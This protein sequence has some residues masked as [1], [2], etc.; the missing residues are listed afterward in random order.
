MVNKIIIGIIAIILTILV[1]FGIKQLIA[2]ELGGNEYFTLEAESWV[3]DMPQTPETDDIEINL[4]KATRGNAIIVDNIQE[5]YNVDG[6]LY[7]FF[8][9]GSYNGTPFNAIYLSDEFYN[10]SIGKTA[11]EQERLAAEYILMRI[12]PEMDPT[13]GVIDGFILA[14][15]EDNKFVFY[16]F[17]DEDWKKQLE[18]TNILWGDDFSN[19]ATLHM[20]S[21]NYQQSVNGIY[22]DK[23]E[24][25]VAW[26]ESL[27]IAGGIA[28]GEIDQQ[29]LNKILNE[30]EIN[31]TFMY[32]R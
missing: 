4:F 13:D 14:K 29:I 3:E 9:R 31:E 16:I 19:P 5:D 11:I 21:F 8:Y 18:Y 28:V 24:Q 7:S 27:P 15:Q 30:Q 25:D 26:F 20:G 1:G 6:E 10:L 22:I 23:L 2:P 12:S 32:V 17:V